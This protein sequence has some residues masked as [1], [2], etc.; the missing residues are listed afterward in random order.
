MG[1]FGYR[2]AE[3]SLTALKA[4]LAEHKLAPPTGGSPAKPKTECQQARKNQR[5]AQNEVG[6]CQGKVKQ[7]AENVVTLAGKLEKAKEGLQGSKMVA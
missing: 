1:K 7:T 5:E 3:E 4:V 2:C 6:K